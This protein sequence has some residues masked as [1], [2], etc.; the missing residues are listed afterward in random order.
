MRTREGDKVQTIDLEVLRVSPVGVE[1][2]DGR[3]TGVES[4]ETEE[5]R[6]DGEGDILKVE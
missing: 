3:R 5:R 6:R 2:R 4:L 1:L